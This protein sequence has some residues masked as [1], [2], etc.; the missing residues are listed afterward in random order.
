M[1][2]QTEK[3]SHAEVLQILTDNLRDLNNVSISDRNIPNL[4]N[5]GKASAA[6][7]TAFHREELME[8]K[9]EG[10]FI[11]IK[12]AEKPSLKKLKPN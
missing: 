3:L 2:N 12:S 8:A 1:R 4:I 9:R 6:I 10:S 5:R 11:A 7:V